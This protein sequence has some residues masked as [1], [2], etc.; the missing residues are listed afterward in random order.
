MQRVLNRT[1]WGL[2]AS[3]MLM[4]SLEGKEILASA[5]AQLTIIV[6]PVILISVSPEAMTINTKLND[7]TA[8]GSLEGSSQS[9]LNISSSTPVFLQVSLT[10][11]NFVDSDF[12]TLM[13][14]PSKSGVSTFVDL[15]DGL[16]PAYEIRISEDILG[17]SN[18]FNMVFNYKC[19]LYEKT[20]VKN[21]TITFT[22][23][24]SE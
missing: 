12:L 11:N 24:S 19:S 22:V 2:M 21:A 13:V 5:T 7:S 4:H 20:L 8:H 14:S 9:T 6:N 3:L 15:W 10:N 23:V 17:P 1:S 18:I 16:T